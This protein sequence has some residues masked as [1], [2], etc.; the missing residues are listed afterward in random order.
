MA[1]PGLDIHPLWSAW[2]SGQYNNNLSSLLSLKFDCFTDGW[3]DVSICAPFRGTGSGVGVVGSGID[4]AGTVLEIQ[5]TP[6]ITALRA[7]R[8]PHLFYPLGNTSGRRNLQH[9]HGFHSRYSV[10]LSHLTI[11]KFRQLGSAV[12]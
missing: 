5:Q 9:H 6:T 11:H 1:S 10:R 2:L 7:Q 8:H 3:G 4:G 12:S